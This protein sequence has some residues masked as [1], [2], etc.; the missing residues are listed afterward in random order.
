M[1]SKINIAVEELSVVIKICE[2]CGEDE[3]LEL[4]EEDMI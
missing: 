2:K 1:N 4:F 3:Y